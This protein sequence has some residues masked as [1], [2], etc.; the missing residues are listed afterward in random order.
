[1]D[2]LVLIPLALPHMT[3]Q[4]THPTYTE[5]S[6]P[7]HFLGWP[8]TGFSRRALAAPGSVGWIGLFIAV[9]N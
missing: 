9:I 3:S 5:E 7:Q 8:A 2:L 1:M 6:G 4:G